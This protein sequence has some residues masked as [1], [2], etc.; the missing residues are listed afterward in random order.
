MA[1]AM[2]NPLSKADNGDG[3]RKSPVTPPIGLSAR[4]RAHCALRG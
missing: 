4:A 2:C 1:S 3:P